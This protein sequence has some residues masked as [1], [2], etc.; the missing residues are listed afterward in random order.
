[1]LSLQRLNQDSSWLLTCASVNLLID[2][3]LKGNEISGFSWFS[4]QWHVHPPLSVESIRKTIDY[5][6]ISQPY[7][8]HCHLETLALFSENIPIVAVPG[9]VPRLRKKFPNR[10]IQAL[11]ESGRWLTLGNIKLAAVYHHTAFS[12]KFS[13]LLIEYAPGEQILY[14][15]HGA[16]TTI[17]SL[18]DLQIKYLLSTTTSFK[19]PFFLGGAV[20]PGI[21]HSIALINHFKPAFFIN[22]HDEKKGKKGLV[23]LLAE[24]TYVDKINT[25]IPAGTKYIEIANYEPVLIS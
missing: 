17:F 4:E 1:M 25:H 23:A 24:V 10:N 19:L 6:L 22:T 18:P 20:N 14:A 13:S 5:I 8:D 15:P 11:I 2:P 21:A 16:A 12:P 7:S 9:A 3:W